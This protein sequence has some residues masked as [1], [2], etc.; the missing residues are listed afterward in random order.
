MNQYNIISKKEPK[1][2]QLKKDL[3]VITQYTQTQKAKATYPL[4]EWMDGRISA[5]QQVLKLIDKLES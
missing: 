1:L 5:Y 4:T 3:I 2:A